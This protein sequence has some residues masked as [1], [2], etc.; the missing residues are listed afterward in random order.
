MTRPDAAP[1]ADDADPHQ[2][3]D[4][5]DPQ[6]GGALEILE[7][8]GAG[9]VGAG[10]GRQADVVTHRQV[11]GAGGLGVGEQG[12]FPLVRA[13]GDVG[14]ELLTLLAGVHRAR[15]EAGRGGVEDGADGRGTARSAG[16]DR[17]GAGLDLLA[18][19]GGLVEAVVGGGAAA[20]PLDDDR[21]DGGDGPEEEEDGED[22]AR[23]RPRDVPGVGEPRT[24]VVRVRV[25]VAVGRGGE[26]VAV[27]VAVVGG[28]VVRVVV[29]GVFFRSG[30]ASHGG[31]S[32]SVDGWRP[33][34]AE[35]TCPVCHDLAAG[36]CSPYTLIGCPP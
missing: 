9:P 28:A 19:A 23:R 22:D 18:E 8:V 6:R 36:W 21:D 1:G 13:G 3:D 34:Q 2:G 26:R 20:G 27:T 31:W 33:G 30:V 29:L 32:L 11:G 12:A 15:L 4:E 17:D 7:G 10:G 25:A 14:D 24:G 35:R 5:P 16:P